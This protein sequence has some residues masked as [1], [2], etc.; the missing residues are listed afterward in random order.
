MD[1]IRLRNVLTVVASV[2]ICGGCIAVNVEDTERPVS[3]SLTSHSPPVLSIAFFD[4]GK[5]AV[6][7]HYQVH[8]KNE[9]SGGRFYPDGVMQIWEREI[10]SP[11]RDDRLLAS[12]TFPGL[13]P[14]RVRY[15]SDS[16]SLQLVLRRDESQLV[17]CDSDTLEWVVEPLPLAVALVS[18]DGRY[19]AGGDA[20]D[21]SSANDVVVL[22]DRKS[23][24][25]IV[26]RSDGHSHRAFEFSRNG[27]LLLTGSD[28]ISDGP[29]KLN[30]W[31]T[32]SGKR[33][34]QI[35]DHR[36]SWGFPKPL[37]STDSRMI[38]FGTHSASQDMHM[39][40]VHLA[41]DGSFVRDL[42]IEDGDLW[43]IAFSTDVAY[44]AVSGERSGP[45]ESGFVRVFR[46][47][48]GKTVAS[49]N[50]S[51]T[52]GVTAVTFTPDGKSIAA[53]TANGEVLIYSLEQ[54]SPGVI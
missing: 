47:D 25:R 49:I 31:K 39:V 40:R 3:R 43:A 53:G 38:A 17:T 19:F 27:E 4:G 13:L 48:S 45:G 20:D 26:L 9:R 32:S 1:S 2:A 24:S 18:P 7:S 11:F 42:L 34:C 12:R 8:S 35:E 28:L 51:D 15:P 29:A 54:T 36:V 33:L 30:I 14:Y 16:T 37:L 52:W 23:K 46:I 41:S 44:L 22:T 5:R 10:D 6:T 21:E 50:V